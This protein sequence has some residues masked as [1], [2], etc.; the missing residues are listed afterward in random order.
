VR[1]VRRQNSDCEQSKEM[2]RPAK[3]RSSKSFDQIL[4]EKVLSL[5][6][7]VREDDKRVQAIG[8]RREQRIRKRLL[9]SN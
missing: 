2:K 3:K 5:S 6:D 9:G 7:R 1:F 8:R 4:H